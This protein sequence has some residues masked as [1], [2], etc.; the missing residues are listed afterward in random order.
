M[1]VVQQGRAV[2]WSCSAPD[3][4]D[5][6]MDYDLTKD[7]ALLHDIAKAAMQASQ[8]VADAE[9]PMRLS[10]RRAMNG[11][12]QDT[13]ET[14]FAI[15]L[16]PAKR[17]DLLSKQYANFVN[18]IFRNQLSVPKKISKAFIKRRA[19]RFVDLVSLSP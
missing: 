6:T 17:S 8:A 13:P 19:D 16:D 11:L 14:L 18:P 4:D 7:T 9:E 1:D 2:S 12:A 3:S 5:A 10:P 15:L